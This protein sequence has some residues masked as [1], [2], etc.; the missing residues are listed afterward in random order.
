LNFV[1]LNLN[2]SGQLE[3]LSVSAKDSNL[4]ITSYQV[5]DATNFIALLTYTVVGYGEQ[6]F[7]LGL[8]T[9]GG[10]WS[11]TFNGNFISENEGWRVLPDETITISGAPSNVT[12]FYFVFLDD[13]SPDGSSSNQSVY[14]QHSVAIATAVVIVAAVVTA[15]MIRR[16]NQDK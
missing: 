14:Q 1:N 2:N 12:I 10:E 16:R 15:V 13:L 3:N 8:S 6:T 4:T 5:F 11:V 9:A 7:N